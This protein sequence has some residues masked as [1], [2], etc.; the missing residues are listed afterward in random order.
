VSVAER[1]PAK[2][3]MSFDAEEFTPP[4]KSFLQSGS[5]LRRIK[6]RFGDLSLVRCGEPDDLIRFDGPVSGFTR[7]RYDKI[8]EGAPF[9][10][11]STFKQRVNFIRQTCLEPG[12]G[13]VL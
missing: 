4:L 5:G 7:C 13:E 8:R 6:Q 11:R 12:C 2:T 1:L 3:G 10:L 9:N